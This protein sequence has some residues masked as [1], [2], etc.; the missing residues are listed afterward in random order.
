MSKYEPYK[1]GR[2]HV[3]DCEHLRGN[4]EPLYV[5]GHC[6]APE[7]LL[8]EMFPD[9]AMLTAQKGK[10]LEWTA[11]QPEPVSLHE[12]AAAQG[13]ARGCCGWAA[14]KALVEEGRLVK[15]GNKRYYVPLRVTFEGKTFDI[16]PEHVKRWRVGL[17]RKKSWAGLA[18]TLK[19]DRK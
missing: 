14:T 4:A 17:K 12:V 1:C 11:C 3:A 15:C 16:E 5:H 10:A 13:P 7:W 6:I 19:S 8:D 2:C 18:G 9:E